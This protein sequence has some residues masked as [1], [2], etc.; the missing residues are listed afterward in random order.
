MSDIGRVVRVKGERGS[1]LVGREVKVWAGLT[2]MGYPD[3][4]TVIQWLPDYPGGPAYD[5]EFPPN[6][7]VPRACLLE[8]WVFATDEGREA[9]E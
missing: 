4:G 7:F 9:A 1:A 8:D 6:D 2:L 3:R 5:V